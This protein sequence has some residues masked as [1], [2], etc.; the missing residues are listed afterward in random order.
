MQGK[1]K[2]HTR[3]MY[4]RVIFGP[5]E[6]KFKYIVWGSRSSY[7]LTFNLFFSLFF[8]S[9]FIETLFS[10]PICIK[11]P[12]ELNPNVWTQAMRN[13]NEFY[14]LIS[15]NKKTL[16]WK[17]VHDQ[18]QQ[19]IIKRSLLLLFPFLRLSFGQRCHSA[20]IRPQNLPDSA[21]LFSVRYISGDG[22]SQPQPIRC[23]RRIRF[24]AH[25]CSELSVLSCSPG[26]D[27][28]LSE[29]DI[30]V[31]GVLF[32]LHLFLLNNLSHFHRAKSIFFVN[33]HSTNGLAIDWISKSADCWPGSRWKFVEG[34]KCAYGTA[35]IVESTT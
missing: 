29:F 6:D 19:Y 28:F 8:G 11:R 10:D 7:G 26:T 32:T 13:G 23:V 34:K 21:R 35:C 17:W 12:T 31:K 14:F 9:V 4:L 16:R 18:R 2:F 1:L 30:L 27:V 5:K 15:K 33:F 3:K 25:I 24:V 22:V 20:R